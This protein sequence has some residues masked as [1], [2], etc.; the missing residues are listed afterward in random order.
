MTKSRHILIDFRQTKPQERL[1]EGGRLIKLTDGNFIQQKMHLEQ[2]KV[3]NLL[4]LL[5]IFLDAV[6]AQEKKQNK[7]LWVFLLYV[8]NHKRSRRIDCACS[9]S[10]FYAFS[11]SKVKNKKKFSAFCVFVCLC[12]KKNKGKINV[13]V[14]SLEVEKL[15]NLK[16]IT[17]LNTI[18]KSFN[19]DLYNY[20]FS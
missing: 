15:V 13:F 4:L 9:N 8:S 19:L 2:R 3:K 11:L 12:K 7:A 18:A 5:F 10:L 6:F 20:F 17:N 1:G 14:R 16:I